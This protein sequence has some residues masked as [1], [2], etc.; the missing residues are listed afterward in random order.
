MRK[1]RNQTKKTSMVSETIKSLNSSQ[2]RC[3]FRIMIVIITLHNLAQRSPGLANEEHFHF[4][5]HITNF[6][7]K[8]WDS[9]FFKET[10]RKRKNLLGTIAGILSQHSPEIFSSGTE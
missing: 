3:Y 8:N 9:F 1:R 4:R 5:T 10:R 7:D 6:I 2:F